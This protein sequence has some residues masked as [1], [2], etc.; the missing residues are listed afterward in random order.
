MKVSSHFE[1]VCPSHSFELAKN[2]K[3]LL[4][5]FEGALTGF[6]TGYI[7]QSSKSKAN[8]CAKVLPESYLDTASINYCLTKYS[9]LTALF[10]QSSKEKRSFKRL[11]DI[12]VNCKENQSR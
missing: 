5:R 1:A 12:T 3:K 2:I 4:N 11:H 10:Y 6:F 7:N 8:I 9:L